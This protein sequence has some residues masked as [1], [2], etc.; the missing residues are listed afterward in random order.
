MP[1]SCWRASAIARRCRAWFFPHRGHRSGPSSGL[2]GRRATCGDAGGRSSDVV[3]VDLSDE[4]MTDEDVVNQ[5]LAALVDSAESLGRG[6]VRRCRGGSTAPR[7]PRGDLEP[8]HH[9]S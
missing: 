5:F 3:L 6:A 9:I 1:P 8:D 4:R 7:N 2:S